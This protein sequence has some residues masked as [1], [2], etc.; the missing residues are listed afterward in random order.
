M[1]SSYEP[2]AKLPRKGTRWVWEADASHAISLIE[3][4]EVFWNGEEWWVRTRSLLPP[5]RRVGITAF[6]DPDPPTDVNDLSRFWEA[7]TPVGG[8]VTKRFWE[9][10]TDPASREPAVA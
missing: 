2:T 1:E 9:R 6:V 4:V 8:E 10:V 5:V 3:V 7:V